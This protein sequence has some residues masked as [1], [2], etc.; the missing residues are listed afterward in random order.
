MALPFF[1]KAAIDVTA[2]AVVLD[3]DTS[4]HI[5][6]VLRM[7]NG[8]Q[9]QLTDGKGNLFT[10]EITDNNRKR[11]AVAILTTRHSPLT[12]HGVSIAI[13]LLKNNTRFEWFLEKA[14]EIG[15]TEIIPIVCERT[16]KTSFKIERMKNILVSAML[17][18]QQCWLPEMGEPVKYKDFIAADNAAQKFIAHCEDE[19][20]KVS[21]TSKLLNPSTSKLILIG[22][23]GDFTNEEIATALK[24]NFIPV[25]LGE[26]RLRTETAGIVAATL[27]F[28]KPT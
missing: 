19:N 9:L 24:N 22:P 14:T 28:I 27:L 12:T 21:L 15:V 3:E 16:E 8:E 18:S 17:Q 5:V 10:C 1:Y 13:S 23:E 11:C 20:N 7:Q 26:T 25:A 4:K 2:T 6:Q